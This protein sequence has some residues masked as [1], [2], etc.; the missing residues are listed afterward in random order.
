MTE[1]RESWQK[2]LHTS[3]CERVYVFTIVCECHEGL[4]WNGKKTLE[5]SERG[6]PARVSRPTE[7]NGVFA[8]GH[9]VK[10]LEVD[11][12]DALDGSRR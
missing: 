5:V 9:A 11:L 2:F 1:K 8:L 7:T 4:A 6:H 12:V 3:E 10:A